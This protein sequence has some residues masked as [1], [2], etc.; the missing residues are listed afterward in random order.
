MQVKPIPAPPMWRRSGN[1]NGRSTERQPHCLQYNALNE[2]DVG[3]WR[4]RDLAVV[5]SQRRSGE[6]GK[7]GHF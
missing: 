1:S 4:L 6:G 5:K 7:G 3:D 2:P